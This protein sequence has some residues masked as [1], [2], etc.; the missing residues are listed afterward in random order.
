MELPKNIISELLYFL[1]AFKCTL[2]I[3]E[4]GKGISNSQSKAKL[5]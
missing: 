4:K 3:N 2:V 5:A 1:V